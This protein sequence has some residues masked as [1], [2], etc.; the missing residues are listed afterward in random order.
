MHDD[1]AS[2]QKHHGGGVM[3]TI[4]EGFWLYYALEYQFKT[5]NNE[6]EYEAILG[7]LW[8]AKALRVSKLR[9]RT[10]SRLVVWQ[11]KGS[12]ET[13]GEKLKQYKET[14]EGLLREFEAYEIDH[15]P[16]A[17]NS[18]ADVLSKV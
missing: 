17:E 8:L 12:C 14:T 4:P 7:G 11:L 6:A 2:S 15:V 16:R 1:G 9:I 10:D 13:R 18:K 5:S 3:L